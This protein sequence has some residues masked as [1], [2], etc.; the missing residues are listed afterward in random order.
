MTIDEY[1]S[2]DLPRGYFRR[3]GCLH[4]HIDGGTQLEGVMS[5]L[6]DMRDCHLLAKLTKISKALA[7]PQRTQQPETYEAHTPGSLE[8]EQFNY[9]ATIALDDRSHAIAILTTILPGL[10]QTPNFVVEVERVIAVTEGDK[11][12]TSLDELEKPLTG[13]EVGHTPAPSLPIEI[14][15]GFDTPIESKGGLT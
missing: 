10:L 11:P 12:W 4:L 7:G 8:E 5:I 13:K 2:P 6:D 9:F 3:L 14:H 1:R 15:H